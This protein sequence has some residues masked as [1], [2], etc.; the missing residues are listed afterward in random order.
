MSGDRVFRI[1]VSPFRL[2]EKPHLAQAYT[3]LAAD[4]LARRLREDDREVQCAAAACAPWPPPAGGSAA[5]AA[6]FTGLWKALNIRH[7]VFTSAGGQ[8]AED[9][10]LAALE[11]LSTAGDIVP[12]GGG[13]AFRPANYAPRLL[14]H[15]ARDPEFILPTGRAAEVAALLEAG[16]ADLPLPARGAGDERADAFGSLLAC[17]ACC[18]PH[19]RPS[20][21]VA[22][23]ADALLYGAVWP[24]LLLALGRDLPRRVF[25][26]G[27]WTVEG[28][29]ASR[30][31]GNYIRPED[32]ARDYGADAVR[33]CLLRLK[34]FAEDGDFTMERFRAVYAEELAG[35]LSGLF[36]R[37]VALAARAP[38]HRLPSKPGDSA[39]FRRLSAATP[40]IRA[41][42]EALR[43]DRALGA[44]RSGVQALTQVLDEGSRAA[45]GQA[46]LRALLDESAWCL[47]LI[48]AW[49]DPFMPDTA[50]RMLL[51]L[52][53]GPFAP[54]AGPGQK[55]PPLFP[56][57]D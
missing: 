17:A 25:L 35:G 57:K 43:F 27:S 21:L 50:S 30:A 51:E 53:V 32:L 34:P 14:A 4:V 3:A 22:D 28:A 9:A 37:R 33:Y 12:S 16:P 24:A 46:G 10:A 55:A 38:E 48:A 8:D 41:D 23:A 54:E 31:K 40:G 2:G 11:K 29:R 1:A 6:D 45:Q 5:A 47:R 49:L 13:R 19:G 56:P 26:H 20:L 39:V 15:I 44:V 52:G 36:A 18:P 42:I 7:D